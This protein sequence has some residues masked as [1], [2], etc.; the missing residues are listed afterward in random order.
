[1]NRLCV[2]AHWDR[3]NII[4]DYVIYYVKALKE[5]CNTII[6]VSDCDL[7]KEEIGKLEGLADYVLAEHHGE[8]D[9]GSYKRGFMLAKAKEL[10]FEEVIF[11]NDSCYGP[12]YP[13]QP[14]FDKMEKRKCGFWGMTKNTFGIKYTSKGLAHCYY[15]HLQ[16]YFMV[17]YSK[18]FNELEIFLNQ[19]KK[20]ASKEL[21]V[22]NYEMK[23]TAVMRKKG[24]KYSVFINKFNHTENC[25]LAKWDI[26][27]EKYGFPFL[28]TSIAKSGLP[29]LGLQNQLYDII[30]I[31]YPV[32]YIVKHVK[33]CNKPYERIYEKLELKDKILFIIYK[34]CAFEIY[35]AAVFFDKKV[36]STFRRIIRSIVSLF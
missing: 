18:L 17:F 31:E 12:F 25:T 22:I 36:L 1:M 34:H 16:S 6:F 28:K 7:N 13:L 20:E 3:D 14:I 32:E 9:F 29:V 24:F 30:P 2:L 5:V 33:R 26:L 19:V 8:Y 11:A 35:L 4:D 10:D 23:L 21:V 27:I 15:P